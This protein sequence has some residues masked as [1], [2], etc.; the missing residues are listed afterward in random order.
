M[1]HYYTIIVQNT[2]ILAADLSVLCCTV[3]AGTVSVV[4]IPSTCWEV[5]C[6]RIQFWHFAQYKTYY[7]YSISAYITPLQS[8]LYESTQLFYKVST[9]YSRTLSITFAVSAI[10]I[11]CYITTASFLWT[12]LKLFVTNGCYL[13]I[14]WY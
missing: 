1:L 4:R 14:L 12:Q 13:W 3:T 11:T 10:T 5:S 8:Y 9:E 6:D 7:W 2:I